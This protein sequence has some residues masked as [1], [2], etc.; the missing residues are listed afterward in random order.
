MATTLK[1]HLDSLPEDDRRALYYA[2]EN[3]L[4]HFVK[5]GED[6]FIGVNTDK[7]P[8]LTPDP[9]FT[10][11]DWRIGKWTSKSEFSPLQQS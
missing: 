5:V 3:G 1:E 11:G 7:I 6:G 10:R 4:T 9:Q 8:Y 2:F